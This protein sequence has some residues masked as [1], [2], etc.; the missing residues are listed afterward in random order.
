MYNQGKH[1]TILYD[2]YL[3]IWT[4]H[5]LFSRQMKSELASLIPKEIQI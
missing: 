5:T 4:T 2:C 3:I 1:V